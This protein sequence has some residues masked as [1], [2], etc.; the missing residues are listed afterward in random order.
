MAASAFTGVSIDPPLVSVCVQNSST[1]W[2]R[3]C[4]LPK[5][6]ISVLSE[7]QHAICLALAMKEGDRFAGL[8]WQAS[9]DGAIFLDGAAAW[10]DCSLH[11]EVTAGD[12]AIALLEIHGLR[13]NPE[14][15][16]LVFHSSRFRRLADTIT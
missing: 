9:E 11:D 12:H 6:G 3:L 4:Q 8:S 5:L 2:P 10:L 1:T 14:Q 7:D 15:A 13:S 16:P